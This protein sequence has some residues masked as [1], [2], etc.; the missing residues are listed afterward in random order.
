MSINGKNSLHSSL[1]P[2]RG[3]EKG[4]SITRAVVVVS[5]NSWHLN[6][7][8]IYAPETQFFFCF[9]F[10]LMSGFWLAT[11]NWCSLDV[12]ESRA[13]WNNESSFTI[14]KLLSRRSF[15]QIKLQI[16]GCSNDCAGGSSTFRMARQTWISLKFTL[17]IGFESK[18]NGVRR[19]WKGKIKSSCQ[20]VGNFPS[21]QRLSG[22]SSSDLCRKKA[23]KSCMKWLRPNKFLCSV[24]SRLP[25]SSWSWHFLRFVKWISNSWRDGTKGHLLDVFSSCSSLS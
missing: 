9:Y 12:Y 25:F 19:G 11:R 15:I 20:F 8:L 2:L 13:P 23:G 22:I 3:H 4:F 10:N 21:L 18:W 5:P 16:V 14:E 17:N 6:S 24:A 1:A 7:R